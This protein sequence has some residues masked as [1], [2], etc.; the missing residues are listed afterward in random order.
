MLEVVKVGEEE[1]EQIYQ[2]VKNL[3]EEVREMTTKIYNF[4]KE[5]EI[6]EAKLMLGPDGWGGKVYYILLKYVVDGVE[7][8]ETRSVWANLTNVVHDILFGIKDSY[9]RTHFIQ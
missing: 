9:E 8:H 7:C 6:K 1:E 2:F 3:T 5:V 4:P